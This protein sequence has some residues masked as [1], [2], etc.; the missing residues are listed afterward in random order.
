MLISSSSPMY[1][2]TMMSG[3]YIHDRFE[4]KGGKGRVFAFFRFGALKW[5]RGCE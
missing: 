1:Y 5:Y 3:P 2:V 4:L